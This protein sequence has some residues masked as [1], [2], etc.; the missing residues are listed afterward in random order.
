M[1]S[2]S[3]FGLCA[4]DGNDATTSAH[5]SNLQGGSKLQGACARKSGTRVLECSSLNARVAEEAPTQ[6]GGGNMRIGGAGR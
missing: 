3:L 1:S 4:D 5:G 6:Q 2:C